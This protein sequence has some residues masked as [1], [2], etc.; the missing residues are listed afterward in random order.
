MKW[1]SEAEGIWVE[2]DVVWSPSMRTPI[3]GVGGITRKRSYLCEQA[4]SKST[5]GRD[6]PQREYLRRVRKACV[7]GCGRLI[8]RSD[9]KQGHTRCWTCRQLRRRGTPKRKQAA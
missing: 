5:A 9:M 1:Y 7:V 6:F 8:N 3:P 4:P 2:G